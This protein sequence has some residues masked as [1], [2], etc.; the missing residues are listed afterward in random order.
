MNHR[1]ARVRVAESLA[2]ALMGLCAAAHGAVPEPVHY[3]SVTSSDGLPIAAMEWGNRSGPPVL[4]V[5]GFGFASEFWNAQNTPALNSQFHMVALDLRGHGASGKPWLESGYKDTRLW[6]DDIAAV[7]RAA[8]I[9]R[10]TIVGWSFG[11]YVAMDYLRHYGVSSI[12]GLVLISSPAGFADRLSPS[13]PGY[14]LA[15]KQRA[16]LSLADNIEGQRFVVRLMTAK[17][18]PREVSDLWLAQALRLPVYVT[19]AM[20]GRSLDNRD[21]ADSLTVPTLFLLGSADTTMP[22]DA[23]RAFAKSRPN[24]ALRVY[25]GVGHALSY[26]GATRFN[27]ELAQ[28]I[29]HNKLNSGSHHGRFENVAP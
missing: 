7:L 23:L 5:H 29:L 4:F 20:R 1:G 17:P 2:V 9:E 8:A 12:A 19:T 27:A 15:A 22:F 10:P 28:F 16:S 24:V 13:V 26:E 14:P 6:A 25:P 18:V 11:G 3:F 21:L